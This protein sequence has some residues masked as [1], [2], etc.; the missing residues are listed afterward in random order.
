MIRDKFLKVLNADWLKWANQFGI[1]PLSSK[2]SQ[3]DQ[4]V[5]TTIPIAYMELRG[6]ASPPCDCG[7]IDTPYCFVRDPKRGSL[8]DRGLLEKYGPDKVIL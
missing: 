4:P 2:C 3:C 5:Y 7:N 8:F 1:E 6:L